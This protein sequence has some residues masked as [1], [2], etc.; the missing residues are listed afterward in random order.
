[1]F[2]NKDVQT[3]ATATKASKGCFGLFFDILALT[4]LSKSSFALAISNYS[5]FE[6]KL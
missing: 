2:D 6:Q 3:E 5:Y 4:N 1:M